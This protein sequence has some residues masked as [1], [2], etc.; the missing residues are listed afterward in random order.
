MVVQFGIG[1]SIRSR[2]YT[3]AGARAIRDAL[4]HNAIRSGCWPL[5]LMS[6]A[7]AN[8]AAGLAKRHA[9]HLLHLGRRTC[10]QARRAS[11]AIPVSH[12]ASSAFASAAAL[13][14]ALT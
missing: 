9:G 7:A 14:S 12:R 5:A 11:P 10:G 6:A 3:Q 13:R 1:N 4:W 8:L 2:D